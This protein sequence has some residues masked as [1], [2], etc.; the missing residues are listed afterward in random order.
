[1]VIISILGISSIIF[2]ET[3]QNTV[4]PDEDLAFPQEPDF[5]KLDVHNA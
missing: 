5:T 1:M 4:V 2:A 3:T